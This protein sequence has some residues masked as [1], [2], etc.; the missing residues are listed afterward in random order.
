MCRA[1]VQALERTGV[2]L[3]VTD[4]SAGI[5]FVNGVAQPQLNGPL[6]LAAKGRLQ[7]ALPGST[8]RLHQAIRDVTA[9]ATARDHILTLVAG[10]GGP[11]RHVLVAPL[12][13]RPDHSGE[14]VLAMVILPA[15][16]GQ[17]TQPRCPDLLELTGAE[18]RLLQAIVKGQRIGSYAA[19]AG[20][21]LSTAKTHLRS[22]FDKTGE[23]RQADLIRRVLSDPRLR[24]GI[25]DRTVC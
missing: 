17:F 24:E 5:R 25:L 15:P 16:G 12:P 4:G 21:A 13:L 18:A 7:A 10:A 14:Q 1:A 20:I 22:L 19:Q 23:R 3:I 2:G 6:L 8:A 9:T 11:T